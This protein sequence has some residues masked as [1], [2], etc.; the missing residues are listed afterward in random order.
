MAA[1]GLWVR[2]QIVLIYLSTVTPE[3]LENHNKTK[4][5]TSSV[6]VSTRYLNRESAVGVQHFGLRFREHLLEPLFH[7]LGEP[8]GPRII[9]CSHKLQ[10]WNI[11][12]KTLTKLHTGRGIT[13]Q[14]ATILCFWYLCKLF[15]GTE[16]KN[17]I[18]GCMY[19]NS[20]NI[21]S[22]PPLIW[23]HKM[24]LLSY[25]SNLVFTEPLQLPI[26]A[27]T[28]NIKSQAD[29]WLISLLS[30]WLNTSWPVFSWKPVAG[31]DLHNAT[32]R[33]R[34]VT[35]GRYCRRSAI[36]LSRP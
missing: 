7:H 14:K 35:M 15:N 31:L 18:S 3:H 36:S 30:S 21:H 23:F 24:C 2:H 11:K 8:T 32:G 5:N 29:L 28:N 17:L 22:F 16:N 1:Q 9:T 27:W 10:H 25:F 12:T 20:C 33:G 19:L 26:T 6:L 4:Q 13:L 34:A